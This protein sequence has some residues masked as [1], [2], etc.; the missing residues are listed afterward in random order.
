M[1][2]A[3][4]TS[5]ATTHLVLEY[6]RQHVGDEAVHA[7]VRAAQV[8]YSVEQLNDRT[9]WVSYDARIRLFE[10]ATRA[11]GRSDA[12][13]HVGASALRSGLSPSLVALLRALGSPRQVFRSLP[14]AVG[15]FTTT[16]TLQILDTGATHATISYELHPGYV[17]SRLDC[18]YAQGLLAVIPQIFG[19]PEGRVIHDECESDGA[20]AC[21]Y[22]VTWPRRSRWR[23]EAVPVDP[24]LAVLRLQLDALEAVATDLVS[25]DDVTDVLQRITE[26]AAYAVL[27]P[28]Y[29]LAVRSPHGEDPLVF[30]A[31]IDEGQAAELAERMLSG[32]DL[33]PGAVVVDVASARRHHG[34]LAALNAENHQGFADEHRMLAVYAQHAAVAL[35]LLGAVE[36]SRLGEKRATALLGLSH[37]LARAGCS[38]AVAQVVAAA[39]PGIVGST[40]AAVLLWD[41]S[42]GELRAAA[43]EG[44]TSHQRTVLL[45][46][47][48]LPEDNPELVD[49]L[50]H[51]EPVTLL[52][53]QASPVLAALL[54]EIGVEACLG[55][56]LMAGS[57]LLGVATAS[58]SD[59]QGTLGGT[60]EVTARLAGVADQAATALFNARLVETIK[61]QSLHDHLTGLPNRALLGDRLDQALRGCPPGTGVAVLFC[62]LDRFKQVNDVLGHAAGDELLRQ[63]A[64]RL[65]GCL[66]PGDSVGRMG[67]DEFAV[68]LRDVPDLD[69]AEEVA[70]RIVSS[71]DAS[72]RIDGR[73]LRATISV[74]IARHGGPGGRADRLL[75]AADTAMYV[76]KQRG[77][78][79]ISCA[80]AATSTAPAGPSLEQ[81][82]ARAAEEGQLRLHFQPIVQ[83]G[84]DEPRVVGAEALL[85]WE[86]PRLGLLGPSAFLA[87]AEESGLVVELDLWAVRAGCAHAA[88]WAT[89]AG[90][91]LQVSVN[92][93]SRTLVDPR[94]VTAVRTALT[95]HGVE[96]SL[97][98]L[99]I[100]ESQSLVELPAVV[101]RLTELR[102]MGVRTALDDFGTG[103]STLSWL[104]QLPVDRVK[105][106]RS[107]ISELPGEAARVLVRGVVALAC[108]LGIDLVAEGVETVEQL[109]ALRAAGCHLLQGYL[110][111]R[112]T[113][114]LVTTLAMPGTPASRG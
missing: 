48:L 66:R 62:D 42:A 98:C 27:A 113:A 104:Q 26:R 88:G 59:A 86:H 11:I 106:D 95:D 34:R 61:H 82:L 15:K 25:S 71:L 31:G 111:G 30:S 21:L 103:Y 55:V 35:D 44:L 53:D 12:M 47:P 89:P 114:E 3:R 46:T 29:L 45:N 39:L 28:A 52:R 70:R 49:M 112:P 90:E 78:N 33:G 109:E 65:L 83:L 84:V 23:R 75:R 4:E 57:D 63:V 74:G 14:R 37:G 72:F 9:K 107:F 17:H 108:E 50:T 13:F 36:G 56:P 77:R 1:P 41:S 64:A 91:S 40:S 60:S 8:P 102:Q 94:L 93:S 22:H 10:Q 2:A 69:S 20:P 81:E 7:V 19:L 76:A 38:D 24:E 68:L 58:W 5:S 32:A 97:L 6:V 105:L 99:E 18:L 96:P 110:L 100:V 54:R 73:E 67:G 16:S 101:A 87:L 43:V 92:L 79:Q 51:R 85:R 80:D